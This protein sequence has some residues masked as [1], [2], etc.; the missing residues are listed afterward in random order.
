MSE[1]R[2]D[3]YYNE[4]ALRI[5]EAL[6]AVDEELLERCVEAPEPV[7]SIG[8]TVK[9][10]RF[11]KRR[12]P[13]W[14]MG[15]TW[16][17]C[18][19]LLA[20][21]FISWNGLRLATPH[22][23]SFDSAENSTGGAM[24]QSQ[25]ATKEEASPE[26]REGLYSENTDIAEYADGEAPSGETAGYTEAEVSGGSGSDFGS[27]L[28]SDEVINWESPDD[29]DQE[30]YNEN[31]Q[32]EVGGSVCDTSAAKP[33]TEEEAR[34]W[35]PLGAYIPQN[36]PEGYRMENAYINPEEQSVTM[37]WSQGADHIMISVSNVAPGT[38]ETVD[39]TKPET[40]DERMYGI[41]YAE[42]VPGEYRESVDNPVFD[43]SDMDYETGLE[44]MNSRMISYD[45]A[46]DTDTP[47]GSFSVLIDDE[48]LLHF[49]GR[50]TPE[51]I[52]N[53]LYFLE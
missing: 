19:G 29:T 4:G 10:L 40:Y 45:D 33:V 12:K 48:V 15:R 26:E 42:T 43:F 28:D 47:R 13:L 27:V 46:G 1:N 23:L 51:E 32:K 6:G 38:M 2:K 18:L 21:G 9:I 36:L 37:T 30:H 22:G 49:N 50:G 35:M 8:K 16:A 3:I 39:I 53:M 17:A 31:I 25:S 34:N 52:W 44:L 20:V 11:G 7:E 14:K 5:L 41:P 24:N